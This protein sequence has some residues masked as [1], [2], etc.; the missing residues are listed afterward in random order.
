MPKVLQSIQKPKEPLYCPIQ[1][2]LYTFPFYIP[3][4]K[5]Q[6]PVSR[7][8]C[9]PPLCIVYCALCIMNYAL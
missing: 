7:K 9:S 3:N 6:L 2:I 4:Q 8:L 5:T 1:K